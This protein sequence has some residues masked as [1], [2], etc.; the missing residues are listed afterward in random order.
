LKS[1]C[2]LQDFLSQRA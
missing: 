2:I 1:C